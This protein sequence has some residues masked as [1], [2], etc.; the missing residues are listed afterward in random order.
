MKYCRYNIGQVVKHKTHGYSAIIV[1]IDSLFQPSGILN[2][3]T[4]QKEFSKPGPW[5]RLLVHDTELITYADESD[6]E[7]IDCDLLI[8]H[9]KL[10]E[11]LEQ[12][13]GHYHRK[14]YSH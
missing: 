5:Y 12:Q 11:Y 7:L 1:D 2:P 4:A 3:H 13:S 8:I 9:P 10:K 14:G 6:L